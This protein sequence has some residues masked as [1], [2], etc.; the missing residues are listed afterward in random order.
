MLLHRHYTDS[1]EK[2][3]A[4]RLKREAEIESARA[5]EMDAENKR[6]NAELARA[7]AEEAAAIKEQ[8]E[9]AAAEAEDKRVAGEKVEAEQPSKMPGDSESAPKPDAV[10]AAPSQSSKPKNK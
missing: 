3:E 1:A 7:E 10:T 6:L 5:R 4:A 8:S 2:V 9:R